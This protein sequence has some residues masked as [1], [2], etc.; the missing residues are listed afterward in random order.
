MPDIWLDVDTAISEAPV[1]I[2]PLLDDTDFKTRETGVAHNAAGMDLVWNFVTTAGAY[3]QTAVTPTTG[4]VYDWTHQGDGMYSIEI[5]AS[6]GGSINNDAEGFGWFTGVATGVLPW[7]GPIIGFRAAAVNNALI[8]GGDYLEVD[9]IQAN[10]AA[11][12]AITDLYHADIQ[13]TRD[14]ANT[15]DE[16]TVSWF[17]N[18]VKQT[19]GITSPTLQAIKRVD[20]T[21]LFAATAMTQI[22]STGSYKLDRTTTNRITVGEAVVAVAVATIDSSSRTFVRNIGRDST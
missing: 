9:V 8:D 4:G 18:G 15:Q 20:G 21:D 22:G 16:W 19:S 11:V 2:L 13:F 1:N 5:P 10:G 12:T 3:T 7:R 14:Q 6:G 17:K